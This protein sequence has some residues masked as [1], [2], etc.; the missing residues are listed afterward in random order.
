MIA[1]YSGFWVLYFQMFDTVLW[2]LKDHVDMTPFDNTVNGALAAVGVDAKF[3]FDAEHVT[4]INAGT[5]IVLQLF[6]SRIVKNLRALPTMIT[7]IAVG[8]LGFV[9]LAISTDPWT[10]MAG[11]TVFSIGEMTAHPKYISYIG[12]IAPEAKKATY[13]GYAFLYGFIGSSVGGITGAKLY[14]VF[15]DGMHQPR[16][17]WLIFVGLG[18]ATIVGL[19]LYDKLVAPRPAAKQV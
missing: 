13:M 17:L 10:F 14:E 2:Y 16:T 9:L 3:K 7:G 8:T 11:I 6:V 19:L 12:L 15:V 1:I 5:I 18:V 4:V